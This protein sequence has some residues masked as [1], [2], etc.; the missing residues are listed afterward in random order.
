MQTTQRSD[1]ASASRA[2]A[3]T[4]WLRRVPHVAGL[5]LGVYAALVLL[6]SI[7]PVL[8]DL[9]R[10]PRQY[11]DDYYVDAPDTSISFA[12]VVALLAVGV[13]TRKRIAWWVLTVYLVAVV[14]VDATVLVRDRDVHAGVALVVLLCAVAVLLAAYNEF[15]TRV[16]RGAMWQ[17]LGIL[18]G[19]LVA[20]TL[21]GWGLVALFPGT[22]PSGERLLWA[23]NRVTA[24]SFLDNDQFGGQPHWFLNTLLGLLGAVALV[25]AA[26]VLFRSQRS[27]NAL[28]GNDESA[29]RG[30]LAR[31]GADDSLGYFAT[32]RDKAV[33]FSR[34]GRAA[35]TYRVELGVCL[36]SGDPIGAPSAWQYA[37]E[38]WQRLARGYGW[39]TAV[40]GASEAGAAAYRRA[41]LT[42]RHLGDEAV[43]RTREFS[44]SGRDMRTVRHAVTRARRHGV[45]AEIRRHRDVPADEMGAVVRLADEWRAAETERGFSMALGRLGDPLDGDCVL[46]VARVDGAI[47]AVLSLVPWGTDGLSLDLVRRDRNAPDGAV[48]LMVTELATRAPELGI[49]RISLNFAV[50]RS[51]FED[52]S[53][54]G[55]GPA[56]RAW[57]ASLVFFSRW[58]Q[59]EALYRANL[60]YQPDWVPRF[61]CF[62]DDHQT[63]RVG[64]AS[65]VTEGFVALP[66]PGRRARG[67]LAHTGIHE[68][69][70]PELVAAE[71][72]HADGSAPDTAPDE[73]PAGPRRPDQVRVRMRKLDALAAEGVDPYPV[74]YPPT[75]T[76]ADA[77]TLPR[78]T[79]VRVAGRLLRIRDHGGVVFATVRDESGDM[80]LVVDAERLSDLQSEGGDPPRGTELVRSFAREFDLGDLVEVSGAIGHSRSGTLSL[81]VT[82]WRM[83]AKCLHPLPDKWKGLSDAETRVRQRYVEL[84]VDPDARRTLTMRSAVVRSLR[85]SLGA[86]GFLEV[87]TPILQQ[88]HGGANAAPLVTRLDADDLDVSLRVAPELYLERLCVAGFEKVFELGRVFRNEAAD[89]THSPE[90]TMLEAFEAHADHEAMRT[91]CRELIQAGAVAAHGREV[92]IRPGPDGAPV[93]VDIS[94]E[95]P[96]VTVH[97][98]VSER[99][100]VDVSPETP[101]DEL[102]L[103]CDEHGL[104]YETDWDSGQLTQRLYGELV[105][106]AT[107]FPTFYTDFPTSTS[108]LARPHST[109]PGIAARWNLVAWGVELGTAYSELTDPIEQ[110]A[111]LTAQSLRAA[112]GDDEAMELDEDFLQAL[113]RGM[114]PTG[115]LGMGVDRLVM[116][117]TGT[118]MRDVLAFPLAKPRR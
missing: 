6:W 3:N 110:R 104:T 96:V 7:S 76:I 34:D 36:A 55:A 9:V 116:L 106:R 91:L 113:E 58:W 31:Y 64:F 102:R 100:G 112:R 13:A 75:H 73:A 88:V 54:V 66:R 56:L 84:A 11:L 97:A 59:L 42:V 114:P 20:G 107:E 39:T 18:V 61:V 29:I 79:R 95:W 118:S 50:F 98:A 23:F 1:P 14:I 25:A 47:V 4:P 22:L 53:R 68:K 17:A 57:R 109:I 37:I 24:L 12:L 108:P 43:L 83:T 27:T 94:G 65:A 15:Y 16:R 46:V 86:R 115:R 90:F 85:D 19:G 32:R 49:T 71:G 89:S 70:P 41:G 5:T 99:V 111:R 8:R 81:L 62:Q 78:G 67:N 38:T 40:A 2:R 52:D 77:L 101:A 105:E 87:E 82:S 28:T 74:A 30:L 63:L 21:V 92:V 80:Q 72:L 33:V 51:A 60:K 117:I 103:L 44:L 26:V 48:E 93:D 69:L 35:V 10:V 45:T